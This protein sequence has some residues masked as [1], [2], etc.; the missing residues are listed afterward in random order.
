MKQGITARWR[1]KNKFG[2]AEDTMMRVRLRFVVLAM[3]SLL[4][5]AGRTWAGE[6][7]KPDLKSLQSEVSKLVEKHYPKAKVTLKDQIIHF[8]FNTRKFM[9]HEL[10]RIGD[11]WQDAREEPGPQPGG[12]YCDI[13]LRLGQYTGPL[14]LP[15][16]VDKRYFKLYYAVP[17]SKRLDRHLYIHLKYPE[18]VPE[19]FL[20]DFKQ[21]TDEFTREKSADNDPTN[22]ASDSPPPVTGKKTPGVEL[23]DQV[24]LKYMEKIDCSAAALAVSS[25]GVLVH[26]RGYGWSDKDKTVPAQ[27]DTMIGIASCEKPITAAAIRQL[28]STGRLNLDDSLF[29]LLKTKPLGKIVDDRV[30]DITVRHLLDHKAGWQGEPIDRALKAAHDK[31]HSDPIP[32]ETLL[33]FIMAQKLKDAPGAKY[34]Y[35]NF[36]FDTLRHVVTKV[37]TRSPVDYFRSDLFQPYGVKELKGFAAPN[38]PRREGDPPL[39]WNDGGPVSASAPALCTF[40]RYFWLTGE[41]R[42]E[43]NPTWQMNGSLPGSTAMML[44]RSDGIDVA[45]IF[46]GRGK[47]SHDE[48]KTELEK[49]IDRLK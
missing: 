29:R 13:E 41:P 6:A 25:K 23:L 33:R 15:L 22:K 4:I 1:S 17:Y 46:N 30:W 45:F 32:V 18:R 38:S 35:C 26:S 36:C 49:V 24:M 42:D 31:G 48:I 5:G 20:K 11:K 40:M 19:E 3:S 37:S 34:E 27:P 9:I 28:A 47:P 16:T 12:I 39:V 43:G 21:L 44:W 10:S 8:E 7:P 14:V 2:G